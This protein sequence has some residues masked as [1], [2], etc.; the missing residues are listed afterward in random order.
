MPRRDNQPT[1]PSPLTKPFSIKPSSKSKTYSGGSNRSE[2]VSPV[3]NKLPRGKSGSGSGSR[4]GSSKGEKSKITEVDLSDTESLCRS[5]WNSDKC[6]CNNSLDS[7]LIDCS[8]CKQ[9]WHLDCVTL[10]GLDDADI[11]KL[12]KWRC[13]FCYVAPVSTSQFSTDDSCLTC[14]NTRTLRDANHAFEVAAAASHIKNSAANNEDDLTSRSSTIASENAMKCIESEFKQLSDRCNHMF[15]D[16]SKNVAKLETEITKFITQPPA[17]ASTI[18]TNS[19]LLQR[20]SDQLETIS[21]KQATTA[22]TAQLPSHPVLSAGTLQ[23]PPPP[24]PATAKHHQNSND[25]LIDDFIDEN[26]SSGIMDLLRTSEFKSENGRSTLSFGEPYT[27]TGSKSNRNVPTSF[28]DVLQPVVD[29]INAIQKDLFYSNHP[30]LK[31]N[32]NRHPAPLINSC[33]VNRYAGSESFLPSHS[34]NEITIHPESSIFTLSLGESAT[35]KFSSI[36]HESDPANDTEITPGH[37]SLYH[38]TRKSQDFFRHAIDRGSIAQGTRYSLTFRCVSWKNRNSTCIIGD[39]NTGMLNFGTNKRS[40]FGELMPGQKYWAPCIR[41][42]KPESCISFS[43]V[44]ILCGIN[45]IKKSEVNSQ[46]DTRNLANSLINKIKQIKQLNPKCYVSVCP[47]LPTKSRELNQ[48]VNFFNCVLASKVASMGP[49]V[50]CVEGFHG[51][52]EHDGTLVDRLSK[53]LDRHGG[54]DILHLNPYG[55]RVLAGLIKR[56]IFFRLN[57]GVDRRKGPS[58]RVNGRLYSSVSGRLPPAS[59]WG[60]RD[61]CQV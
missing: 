49:G 11:N 24:P 54:L 38:M 55:A 30:D 26:L 9:Y 22:P 36:H 34:D 23:A 10:N 8:N 29:K 28:P 6:P 21:K 42:I 50:Q 47:L 20:I 4:T 1:T 40:T 61:G 57:R 17:V 46:D 52:A 45:D 56:C 27:Y 31:R 15:H 7:W 25:G 53:T 5:L 2:Y 32:E 35:V 59:Q 48:K 51:F 18:E 3:I 43:N 60:S 44:V 13:P 33:L 16:V 39:S 19:V 12:L 37:R 14:R 41:D 58:S